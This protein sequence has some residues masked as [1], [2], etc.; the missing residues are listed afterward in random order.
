MER[1]SVGLGL[2]WAAGQEERRRWGL[3]WRV[4]GRGGEWEKEQ[5]V[6]GEAVHGGRVW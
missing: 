6:G 1:G 2:G 4:A 3:G 5:E